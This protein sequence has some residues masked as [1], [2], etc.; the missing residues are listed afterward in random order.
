MIATLLS[1]VSLAGG[2][3]LLSAYVRQIGLKAQAEMCSTWGGSPTRHA[4]RCRSTTTGEIQR[5]RW[6]TAVETVTGVSL[7]PDQAERAN[8]EK[9]DEAVP[10]ARECLAPRP[11]DELERRL[12]EAVLEIVGQEPITV[13]AQQRR[14][15]RRQDAPDGLGGILPSP[16]RRIIAPPPD[17]RP[18]SAVSLYPWRAGTPGHGASNELDK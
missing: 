11:R 13:R 1:L 18:E 4:L 5:N 15:L 7:L 16:L 14:A 10:V 12:A 3:V 17:R 2:P 6:R 9:A 8:P